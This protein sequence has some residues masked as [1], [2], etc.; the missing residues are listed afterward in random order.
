M[1]VFIPA[2][3]RQDEIM[4]Q[5]VEADVRLDTLLAEQR[6]YEQR[7]LGTGGSLYSSNLEQQ[8]RM[9]AQQT[10]QLASEVQVL[11]DRE[12]SLRLAIE[13]IRPDVEAYKT[14]H[15]H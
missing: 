12:K 7:I 14:N 1:L 10:A 15:L 9:A 3:G 2:C 8:A 5:R 13:R 11:E 6:G 4:R